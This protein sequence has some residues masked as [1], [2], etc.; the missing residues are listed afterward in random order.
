MRHLIAI[1]LAFGFAG[2]STVAF[3]DT[4]GPDWMPI[5]QV[6]Q[7]L[8]EAGYTQISELSADDGQWEGEGMK[9]G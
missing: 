9:N 2:A 8:K 3:A 4:P 6:V 5:E 1:T 7:K